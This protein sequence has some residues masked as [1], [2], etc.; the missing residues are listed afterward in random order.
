MRNEATKENNK[1]T[2]GASASVATVA[3]QDNE[4]NIIIPAIGDKD[5]GGKMGPRPTYS[6]G[7]V[8]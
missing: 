8:P 6:Q 7:R 4:N 3:V 5:A 1:K 2:G